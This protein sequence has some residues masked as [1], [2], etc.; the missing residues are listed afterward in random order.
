[1]RTEL[2]NKHVVT[3]LT[4]SEMKK[5]RKLELE[6]WFRNVFAVEYAK[7]AM[8]DYFKIPRPVTEYELFN[9]AYQKEQE[10]REL[11]GGDKLPEVFTLNIF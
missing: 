1:M 3:V 10:Y 5:K 11:T 8:Y 2:P 9:E 7:M 4:E 6:T